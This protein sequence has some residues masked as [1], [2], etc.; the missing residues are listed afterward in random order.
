M[1]ASQ[2]VV[3]APQASNVAQRTGRIISALIVA[4]ML[5]DGITKIMKGPQVMAATAQIQYPA[6]LVPLTGAIALICTILCAIPRMAILGVA[7]LTGYLGGA[8]VIQ[9]RA[10]LFLRLASRL[11]SAFW[12]GRAL[13]ARAAEAL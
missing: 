11:F 4:F 7:L 12:S 10:G 5:F 13:P 8:V 1:P 3:G 2:N 6:T 9:L